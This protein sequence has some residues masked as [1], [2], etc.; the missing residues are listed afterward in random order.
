MNKFKT[1]M[2]GSKK[3]KKYNEYFRYLEILKKIY[4]SEEKLDDK[5]FFPKI[6]GI[7]R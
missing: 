7:S 5:Y 4:F 3:I 2:E 1:F 6:E